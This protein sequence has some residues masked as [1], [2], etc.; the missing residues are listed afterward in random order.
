VIAVPARLAPSTGSANRDNQ[1][2]RAVARYVVAILFLE[3]IL[4]AFV[5]TLGGLSPAS[6]S[7]LLQGLIVGQTALDAI[8]LILVARSARS[9]PVAPR[10]FLFFVGVLI[11]SSGIKNQDVAPLAVITDLLRVVVPLL[12]VAVLPADVLGTPLMK[13]LSRHVRPLMLLLV[14]ALGGLLLARRAGWGGAYL[15]GDPIIPLLVYPALAAG[16][17]FLGRFSLGMSTILLVAASLK[18]TAWITALLALALL[19]LAAPSRVRIRVVV[20]SA[21]VAVVVLVAVATLG[22][23]GQIS[24]RYLTISNALD[25]TVPD[26]SI[27]QRTEEVGT[28]VTRALAN[29]IAT[30]ALGLSSEPITLSDQVVTHAIHNT[31][32]FLLFSGGLPWIVAL[33]AGRHW[34]GRQQRNH[35]GRLLALVALAALF[36]SIGGNQAL[37]PSFGI[38]LAVVLAYI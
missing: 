24:H 36:D 37:A 19:A 30:A 34:R 25:Q 4:V 12:W 3:N 20:G 29:P 11:L 23:G 22:L 28:E 21:A 13:E 14:A 10:T 33:V 32:V 18:R 27:A 7:Q 31:P 1:S 35:D 16:G 15:S 26:L 9:L 2:S 17:R 5:G 38:S 6:S 8:G